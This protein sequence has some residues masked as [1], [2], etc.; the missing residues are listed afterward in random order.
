MDDPLIAETSD[1]RAL[2][3]RLQAGDKAACAECV[4]LHAPGLYRLARRMM[5]DE[6]EAE[7]VVQETLL[8]AFKSIAHFEGR[9]GLRTWLYRIAYNAALMRLRRSRPDS[10]SV[11][12]AGLDGDA[13]LPVP[14]QMFDWCCLPESDFDSREARDQLEAAVQ[15]L[16]EK[17]KVVFV[18][19]ELEGLSTEAAAE[20]LGLSPEAVK[21]RLHRARLW[22]RERLAAYFTELAQPAAED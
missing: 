18:L 13:G 16:P 22:L 20:A 11:E 8:S 12:G 6:A 21:T 1:E 5:R 17:L 3:A 10:V 15:A 4:E 7:D 19:R 9:S 2:I 14:R